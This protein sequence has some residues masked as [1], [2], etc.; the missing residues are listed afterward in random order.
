MD[1]VPIYGAVRYMTRNTKSPEEIAQS[2]EQD[3]LDEVFIDSRRSFPRALGLTAYHIA[4]LSG[5][6]IAGSIGLINLIQNS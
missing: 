1:F 3:L 6:L 4:T 5:A 2:E